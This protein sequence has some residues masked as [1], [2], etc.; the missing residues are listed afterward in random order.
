MGTLRVKPIILLCAVPVKQFISVN[1]SNEDNRVSSWRLLRL[2]IDVALGTECSTT[3]RNT[4]FL[5]PDSVC[6][7]SNIRWFHLCHHEGTERAG[8]TWSQPA[9]SHNRSHP[10]SRSVLAS[11]VFH[12]AECEHIC[13]SVSNPVP[14][15]L[16]KKVILT[17]SSLQSWQDSENLYSV[18]SREMY[19]ES[20]SQKNENKV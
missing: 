8:G 15:H 11:S 5:A 7:L 6:D 20:G 13:A 18:Y 10:K 4:Y 14:V 2:K 16:Q 17:S 12:L 9:P 19:S 1:A 3:E